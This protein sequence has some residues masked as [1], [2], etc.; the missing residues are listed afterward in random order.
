MG[1]VTG[2]RELVIEG[3]PFIAIY[4]QFG[5]DQLHILRVLHDAQQWP[6][7]DEEG[8]EEVRFSF[9]LTILQLTNALTFTSIES[10][11]TK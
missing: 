6:S 7:A 5:A 9:S 8:S 2:T 11:P 10:Y 1:R 4:R 3:V